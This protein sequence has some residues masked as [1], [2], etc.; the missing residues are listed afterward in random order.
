MPAVTWASPSAIRRPRVRARAVGRGDGRRRVDELIARL[1]DD[2]AERVGPAARAVD[3]H[4]ALARDREARR[5]AL[6]R[7]RVT[8]SVALLEHGRARRDPHRNAAG[9]E[10]RDQSRPRALL[11]CGPADA[12]GL[13]EHLR[14]ARNAGLGLLQLR[15]AATVAADAAATRA[16]AAA[17]PMTAARSRAGRRVRASPHA[18]KPAAAKRETKKP[19][20]VHQSILQPGVAS[21][22]NRALTHRSAVSLPTRPGTAPKE[23]LFQAKYRAR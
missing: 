20:G 14:A 1:I 22:G 17:A 23:F 5:V 21:H 12:V 10:L 9:V 2:E 18:V 16:G 7:R 3:R 11:D 4:A 6:R 13:D 15:P 19:S 8:E